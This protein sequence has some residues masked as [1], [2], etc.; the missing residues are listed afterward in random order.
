LSKSAISR[1][2]KSIQS[3]QDY[4]E[5]G[6]SADPLYSGERRKQQDKLAIAWAQSN[7]LPI[8]SEKS[9][10]NKWVESGKIRGGESHVYYA[11]DSNGDIW[12]IK[13]NNLTYH[14]N[15][16]SA[17]ADRLRISSEYFPD[18]TLEIIGMV[19]TSRGMKPLLQQPFV[20]TDKL[21]YPVDIRDSLTARGFKLLDPDNEIW[22]SPDRGYYVSD[23]GQN[24]VLV[25]ENGQLRFIDIIFRRVSVEQLKMDY[26][27][28]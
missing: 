5:S 1:I 22:L 16:L 2:R 28:V 18:T 14:H 11:Q 25:D 21:A 17:Y 8:I 3:L 26:P 24:N 27:R 7:N 10:L 19:N 20:V 4:L 15:D 12:A 6:D 13:M 23:P 9:F